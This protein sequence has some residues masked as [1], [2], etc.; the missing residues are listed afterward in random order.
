MVNPNNGRAL[1]RVGRKTTTIG[2]ASLRVFAP[3]VLDL[4]RMLKA[5]ELQTGKILFT[6]ARLAD[7][8]RSIS[9]RA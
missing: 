3:L 5:L 4:L 6:A 9:R 8:T 1:I 7:V 2:T